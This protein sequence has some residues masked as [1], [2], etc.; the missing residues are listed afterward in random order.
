MEK[1]FYRK[2]HVLSPITTQIDIPPGMIDLGI[3]HPSPRLLP[4]E[5]MKNAA[6]HRLSDSDP[7]YLAYGA[8]QGDVKFRV[9]L[10]EFLSRYYH[11]AVEADHLFITSGVSFALDLIC[12][13]FTRPGDTIFVEEPTYFLALRIFEDHGLNVIGIPMDEEGIIIEVLEEHLTRHRPIFVYTIPTFHNPASIT[14]SEDRRQK[15]VHLSQKHGFLIVADEVYHLL[16]YRETPP[17][18]MAGYA[19]NGKL[20]SLGSF[21]KILAPGLRLGWIQGESSLLNRFIKCGLLD[22]GGGLN[23]FM[24]G[25]VRSALEGG[26]QDDHLR[27]LKSTYSERVGALSNALN[28]HLPKSIDFREPTGGYFG[29]VRLPE[30]IDAGEFLPDAQERNVKYQ[31]GVKFSSQSGLTQFLRLSFSYYDSPDLEKGA[32]ILSDVFRERLP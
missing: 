21:S 18:P 29:W 3:G 1:E 17:R 32:R 9:A 14:L 16:S 23:P 19:E 20:L 15:L 6:D 4:L 10:A 31:P 24:S 13:L 11:F 27:F 22:S 30:G 12:T 25:L 5:K 26:F 28:Q 8:E 7:S 2:D